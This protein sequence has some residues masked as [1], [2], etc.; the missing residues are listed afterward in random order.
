MYGMRPVAIS[1]THGRRTPL[2]SGSAGDLFG[3]G[4]SSYLGQMRGEEMYL[5]ARDAV[6]DFDAL[7]NRTSRLANQV[8]RNNIIVKYGLAEPENQDKLLYR[9][10]RTAFYVSQVD[11]STGP[12]KYLVFT[13]SRPI[14]ST[15]DLRDE[16]RD[17]KADVTAAEAFGVLPEPVVIE[18][19]V[20]REVTVPGAPA[21]APSIVPYIVVG[22]LVL[23]GLALFGV[24]GG[25]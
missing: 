4:A 12:S 8:A 14:N 19:I 7:V 17:F 9:R 11:Q 6:A 18:R 16:N 20:T 13:E 21:P 2:F 22:G 25:K 3:L 1:G 24:I 10:N 5:A 15:Q 23:A